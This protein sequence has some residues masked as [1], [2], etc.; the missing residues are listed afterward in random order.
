MRQQGKGNAA[1]WECRY[2]CLVPA[3]FDAPT[4]RVACNVSGTPVIMAKMPQKCEK[5]EKVK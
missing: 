4:V 2:R 1:C 5:R 3:V